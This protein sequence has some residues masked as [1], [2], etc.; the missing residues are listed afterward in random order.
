LTM[1]GLRKHQLAIT[2]KSIRLCFL[3]KM[4]LKY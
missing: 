3:C 2:W 1:F 4:P